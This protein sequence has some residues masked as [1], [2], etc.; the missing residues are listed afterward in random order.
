MNDWR[1]IHVG[2]D[3]ECESLCTFLAEHSLHVYKTTDDPTIPGLANLRQ[4]VTIVPA[5]GACLL[6]SSSTFTIER[7]G[8]LVIGCWILA[9]VVLARRLG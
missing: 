1:A 7:H 8:Y 3:E 9:F 4:R 2:A 5:I 6:F